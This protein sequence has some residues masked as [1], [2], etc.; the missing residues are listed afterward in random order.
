[1]KRQPR[2]PQGR[3]KPPLRRKRLRMKLLLR[4]FVT[5]LKL[6]QKRPKPQP[7]SRPLQPLSR[8]RWRRMRL[9]W[10]VLRLGR[11]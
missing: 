11:P 4:V 6:L 7:L 8:L 5:G 10:R 9:M 3:R 1:L 2:L